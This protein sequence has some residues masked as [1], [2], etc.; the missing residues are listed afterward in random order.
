MLKNLTVDSSAIAQLFDNARSLHA[1]RPE[2][3]A[4]Q[5][6]RELVRLTSL[7]P[8]AFNSQ[9]ARFV[10]VQSAAAKARLA[11]TLARGN[12]DKT[13]AAPLTAIV[14]TDT[15][16]YETL[17]SASARSLYESSAVMATEHGFRN[18]TLQGAYLIMAARA[19]GLTAGPMSGFDA[20][21]VN[22]EFF[23]DGRWQVNFLVNLGY[24]D[25]KPPS[26]PRYARL[27]WE[28][29]AQIL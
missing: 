21:K 2:P 7:G 5:T 3:V 11:P 23:P 16:F 27:S 8:T 14:A 18:G 29:Y 19:L 10:F 12:H 24:G 20:A 6:L 25:G 28:Q 17:A 15:R 1:F 13:M 4:E 22:Q 9:P 26:Q